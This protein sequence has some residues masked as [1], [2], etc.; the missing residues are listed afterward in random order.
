MSRNIDCS[1]ALFKTLEKIPEA[2]GSYSCYS[3]LEDRISK[4]ES[5]V[6][7]WGEA[8]VSRDRTLSGM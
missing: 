6:K 3:R 7:R 4:V 8:G 1:R 5:E 2:L